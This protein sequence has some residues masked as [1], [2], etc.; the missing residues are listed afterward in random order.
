M[1]VRSRG[2]L[3]HSKRGLLTQP[4]ADVVSLV[5]AAADAVFVVIGVPLC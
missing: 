5:A 2:K 1:S 3:T 4:L